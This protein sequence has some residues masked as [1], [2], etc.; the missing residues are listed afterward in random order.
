MTAAT[1]TAPSNA[2]RN[3]MPAPSLF[4]TTT[5]TIAAIMYRE[6]CAMLITR[7]APNTRESP[8]ATMNRQA[9]SANP[10]V[11]NSRNLPGSTDYA[12]GIELRTLAGL[13]SWADGEVG[14]VGRAGRLLALARL[15]LLHDRERHQQ[16]VAL[17]VGRVQQD[18]E[19]ILA[20][21]VAGGPDRLAHIGLLVARADRELVAAQAVE[22]V[23]DDLRPH[24]VGVE[25]AGRVSRL[26]V[27]H[28]R[29]VIHDR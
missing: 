17:Q 27:H 2:G 1:T 25:T 4:A 12:V 22:G 24:L 9:A 15:E 18:R 7:S 6:P 29:V 8:A 16:V 13:P 20:A 26:G 23:A 28:H 11:A 5:D 3:P 14:G 21:R 10:P 19:G